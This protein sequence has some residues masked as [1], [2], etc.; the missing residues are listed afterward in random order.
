VRSR[1]RSI[2][3]RSERS[4]DR[5]KLSVMKESWWRHGEES[6]GAEQRRQT[7]CGVMGGA[8]RAALCETLFRNGVGEVRV[9]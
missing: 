3:G 2:E 4:E 9:K 8:D 6:A 1:L 5:V 7:R